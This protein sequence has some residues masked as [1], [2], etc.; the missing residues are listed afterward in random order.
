[1]SGLRTLI[2]PEVLE[3]AGLLE[4]DWPGRSARLWASGVPV[5][6]ATPGAAPAGVGAP[7]AEPAAA[8]AEPGGQPVTPEGAPGGVDYGRIESALEDRFARMEESLTQRLPAPVAPAQ[9]PAADPFA[10]TL[11]GL[12]YDDAEQHAMRGVLEPLFQGVLQQALGPIQQQN[13]ELRQQ[14]HTL[15]NELDAGEIEERYPALANQEVYAPVAQEALQTAQMLGLQVQDPSQVP[16][17]LIEQAYLARLG[18]ERVASETP[19]GGGNPALEAAGGATPPAEEPDIA[20]SIVNAR[21]PKTP[22]MAYWGG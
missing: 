19:A 16:A 11:G 14:L 21:G 12:G 22:G 1:M 10:D 20:Q 2:H 6:E 18:R 17:R 7:A 15:T 5:N 9:P 4:A 8:G 3:L 13:Q